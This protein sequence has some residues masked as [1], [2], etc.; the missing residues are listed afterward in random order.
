MSKEERGWMVRE[1]GAN[2]WKCMPFEQNPSVRVACENFVKEN[3]DFED[4]DMIKVEA[5]VP[6]G[7][8]GIAAGLCAFFVKVKV[9]KKFWTENYYERIFW[10]AS[11]DLR[12]KV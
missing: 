7:V 4:G 8:A 6:D 10:E 3:W 2:S 11:G 5:M 12:P 9:E 1:P